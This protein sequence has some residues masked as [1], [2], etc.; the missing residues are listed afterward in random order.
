LHVRLHH[1]RLRTRL[2][3]HRISCLCVAVKMNH[4]TRA[5]GCQ[6]QTDGPP[7]TA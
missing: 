4:Y 3:A 5:L 1:A 7:N 6:P 2:S